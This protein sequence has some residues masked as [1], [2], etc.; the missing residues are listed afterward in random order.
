M[1]CRVT[2]TRKC[3]SCREQT[4]VLVEILSANN[5]TMDSS[6]LQSYNMHAKKASMTH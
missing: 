3:M 4:T 6:T 1:N 2:F 5:A